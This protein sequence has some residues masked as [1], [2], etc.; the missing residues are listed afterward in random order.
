MNDGRDNPGPLAGLFLH[1]GLRCETFPAPS[2]DLFKDTFPVAEYSAQADTLVPAI[3][4]WLRLATLCPM[5][6][7]KTQCLVKNLYNAITAMAMRWWETLLDSSPLPAISNLNLSS[8]TTAAQCLAQTIDQLDFRF[9]VAGEFKEENKFVK[10]IFGSHEL[11]LLEHDFRR[12]AS[13]LFTFHSHR[14]IHCRDQKFEKRTAYI[15]ERQPRLSHFG[16]AN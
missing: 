13:Q 3:A 5:L 10:L 6:L 9:R 4:Q 15:T 2:L 11:F 16:T 14:N 7:A 1:Y 8:D 12:E